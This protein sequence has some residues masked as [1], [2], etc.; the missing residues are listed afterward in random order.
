MHYRFEDYLLDVDRQELRHGADLVAIEPQVFDLLLFLIRNRDRVVSK[1]D[2]VANV[3][4]G[5]AI[6]DSTLSSRITS[7]RQVIGDSGEEQRLIRTVARKGIRFI[8]EVSECVGSPRKALP[9]TSGYTAKIQPLTR[10]AETDVKTSFSKPSIAVLPFANLSSNPEQNYFA[11]GLTE[12]IITALSYWQSFHVIARNSTF[13]YKGQSPDVRQI[14]VH[15]GVQYVLEGSVRRSG[16]RVRVSVQLIDGTTG[17]HVW[18][19]RV[20]R[21]LRGFFELQDEI[22]QIVAAKV[23]PEFARAEQ[24]RAVRKPMNSLDAW[25]LYQR[26]YASLHELTKEGLI[27]GQACFARAIEI[28]PIDSRAYSA[29]AYSIFVYSFYGFSDTPGIADEKSLDY[30]KRAIALDEG[31]AQAHDVLAILSIHS[32][33]LETAIAEARRAVDINPNFAHA[34]VPLGNALSLIGRP[35][36][37]IPYLEKSIR[38][39]PDDPRVHV[40]LAILAE[41]HLNN[42]DY[43][44]A[45]WWAG[46]AIERKGDYLHPFATLASALAHQGNTQEAATA[47]AACIR[48]HSDFLKVHPILRFY[49]NPADKEHILDG[50]RKAGWDG[51][52]A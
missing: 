15:L 42:R 28:D 19:S 43:Q 36:E 5:R 20:D 31:D 4:N 41:A 34:Y 24:K 10:F 33:R 1:N 51:R 25:E 32:H 30:A 47:L 17:N 50:L 21:D 22:T 11:D 27:Q 40:Y 2:L 12:D 46:K 3:W 49:R 6:S 8:G 45:I 29:M 37:G 23:E 52:G 7:A 14:A 39:N 9:L 26:G 13:Q 35:A 38:L 16:D 44:Q 18:A 48:L